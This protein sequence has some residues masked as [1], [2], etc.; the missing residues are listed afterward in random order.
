[1]TSQLSYFHLGH[2]TV[3][4][5]EPH[6]NELYGVL[7][8]GGGQAPPPIPVPCLFMCCSSVS[9]HQRLRAQVTSQDT[10]QRMKAKSLLEQVFL[11]RSRDLVLFHSQDLHF[12]LR[13]AKANIIRHLSE[14]HAGFS[15]EEK[16]VEPV[17]KKP[18]Q[19]RTKNGYLWYA[20]T[21][22]FGTT[23]IRLFFSIR[24][25][26]LVS[27]ESTSKVK[28]PISLNL[29]LCNVKQAQVTDAER[30][31]CFKV[32]SPIR[33]LLLQAESTQDMQCW[34]DVLNYAI[35]HALHGHSMTPDR[36]LLPTGGAEGGPGPVPGATAPPPS[37]PKSRVNISKELY[38]IPGNDVCADCGNSRPKWASINLSV[39]ICIEC[40][41]VHR[42]LGVYVSQVGESGLCGCHDRW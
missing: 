34:M 8:V 22:T 21:R 41:G 38:S 14:N 32:I 37:K 27:S 28:V 19:A 17:Q 42:S 4:D 13:T 1:M 40:S 5:A 23:W 33:V 2:I 26:M 7:E 24:K 39:L 6:I 18:V 36:E 11:S 29:N 20:E 25:G 10:Q 31:F 12:P 35:I 3:K 15:F 9:V 16:E 30:N